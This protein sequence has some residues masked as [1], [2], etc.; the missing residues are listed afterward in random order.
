M[1]MT[2]RLKSD[3]IRAAATRRTKRGRGQGQRRRVPGCDGAGTAERS[4]PSPRSVAAAGRSYPAA[5]VRGGWEETPRVGRQGQRPSGATPCPRPGAA[6]RRKPASKARAAGR[7]DPPR[8][9]RGQ[10]PRG[11]TPHPRPGEAGRHHLRPEARGG[12]PEQPPRA[13]GQGRWLGGQQPE[14]QWL[15]G[16]RRA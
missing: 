15:P 11:A 9:G 7:R 10:Q 4:Y 12:G 13:R 3:F 2:F 8:R 5:E 16:R 14:E 6:R 1:T